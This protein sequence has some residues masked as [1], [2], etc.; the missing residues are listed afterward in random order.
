MPYPAGSSALGRTHVGDMHVIRPDLA[1]LRMLAEPDEAG[2]QSAVVSR[3]Q[4]PNTG[5]LAVLHPEGCEPALKLAERVHIRHQAVPIPYRRRCALYS[6]FDVCWCQAT[7][8]RVRRSP[9]AL[10]TLSTVV[11]VGLPSAERAL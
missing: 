9:R 7:A 11:Q 6:H 3:P 1:D 4:R 5:H 2:M 8:L 10:V